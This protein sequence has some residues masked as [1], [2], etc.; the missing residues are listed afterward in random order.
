MY[1]NIIALN[2]KCRQ[3]STIDHYYDVITLQFPF[4]FQIITYYNDY[5][6]LLTQ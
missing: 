4:P 1:T 5:M 6:Y 3:L 2:H